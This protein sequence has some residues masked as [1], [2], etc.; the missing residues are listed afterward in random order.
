MSFT[1]NCAVT[2][3]LYSLVCRRHRLPNRF[4]QLSDIWFFIFFLL[5]FYSGDE[6]WE[7]ILNKAHF[8]IC[9]GNHFQLVK[10]LAISLSLSMLGWIGILFTLSKYKL[11]K[12]ISQLWLKF[13]NNCTYTLNIP[14]IIRMCFI[15]HVAW[16]GFYDNQQLVEYINY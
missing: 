2:I 9:D 13:N 3:F 4:M 11:M 12:F 1:Q 15:K 6:V 10:F 16:Y 7:G 5:P 8:V 14:F